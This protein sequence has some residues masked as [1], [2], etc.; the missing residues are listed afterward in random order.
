MKT[1]D[2][3]SRKRMAVLTFRS[4]RREHIKHAGHLPPR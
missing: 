1:N 4:E 3:S 2:G